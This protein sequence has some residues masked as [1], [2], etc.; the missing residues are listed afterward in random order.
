MLSR[1]ERPVRPRHFDIHVALWPL[2]PRA[3]QRPPVYNERASLYIG[4]SRQLEA[5]RGL[6]LYRHRSSLYEI[7]ALWHASSK[8]TTAYQHAHQDEPPAGKGGHCASLLAHAVHTREAQ[9]PCPH[10]SQHSAE[11]RKY[12]EAQWLH[13]RLLRFLSNIMTPSS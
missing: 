11:I 5:L 3:I 2:H 8:H 12:P 7:D 1:Q 6:C 13:K 4:C 10:R 9:T